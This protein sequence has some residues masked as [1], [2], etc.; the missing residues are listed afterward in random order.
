MPSLTP[1][2]LA[3]ATRYR[4][5]L[6]D[7][8]TRGPAG[9]RLGKGTGSS[10]EF[11]DRRAYVPGDD[12]R[13]LDWKAYARTD[14]VMVRLYR[15]EILP[16]VELL[17]DGSLSMAVE[18]D[19]AQLTVDLAGLLFTCARTDGYDVRLVHLG[20]RPEIVS[21]DQLLDRG[22]AL[23]GKAPLQEGVDAALPLMRAGA[24]R[25]LISDFLSPLEPARTV[26][27]IAARGG[28]LALLQ[29]LGRFDAQPEVGE[30][31]R[32]QDAETGGVLDIVLDARTV[33]Q[34]RERL[35]RLAAGLAQEARRASGVF[36]T[37]ES[38]VSLERVCRARL[39]AEGVLA[40]V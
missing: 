4:L 19:K 32:L 11:Q 13:H 39:A 1:D 36:L 6:R 22:L 38:D 30:A 3:L 9:E 33:A 29:I 24:V 5:A 28:G 20:D 35:S 7:L 26:R 18:D 8:P 10:L 37:V 12:V 34:Y 27:R 23:D 40:P 2:V 31:L 15:E 16:R 17:V 25:V 21:Y 14:Q